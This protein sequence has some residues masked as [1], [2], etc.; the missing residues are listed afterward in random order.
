MII[1]TR[2]NGKKSPPRVRGRSRPAFLVACTLAAMLAGCSAS[3]DTAEKPREPE[4]WDAAIDPSDSPTTSPDFSEPATLRDQARAVL[5]SPTDESGLIAQ[6]GGAAANSRWTI[7]LTKIDNSRPELVKQMLDALN[8]TI[9]G[10]RVDERDGGHFL[11][12][13]QYTDAR[14]P[15]ARADLQRVHNYT[16]TIG[17]RTAHPYAQAFIAPPTAQSLQGTNPGYDLR[18]VRERFGNKALY[19]L[20]IAIYGRSDR[21]APST[22]NLASFRRAAEQAVITLRREGGQAFYYHG[23]SRSTVTLGVFY[24]KDHDPTTLPPLESEG[25]K[26]ARA[27]HP[28]NLLNGQGITEV[29]R[30]ERGNK[31]RR[32]Q[33]SFLV[34][35]PKE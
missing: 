18:N 9:P 11:I 1:E 28:L 8:K 4:R 20:Q 3:P 30:D 17:E 6:P 7:V 26:A 23:P 27:Q 16:V 19:T 29:S 24:E 2:T 15:Q 34:G 31:V 14:T 25:L 35:I 12:L 13:G 5:G 33:K 10:V 32:P 21:A 22:E